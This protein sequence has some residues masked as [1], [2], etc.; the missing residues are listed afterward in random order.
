ML[1]RSN[2]QFLET[3][4]Q[5]QARTTSDNYNNRNDFGPSPYDYQD[6]GNQGYDLGNV[7]DAYSDMG[8]IVTL[9]DTDEDI[10]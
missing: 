4:A 2:V 8:D 5:A 9:D 3:R 10:E 1:F 6:N 7:H